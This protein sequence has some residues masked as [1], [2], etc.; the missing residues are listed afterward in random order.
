MLISLRKIFI[1]R[2]STNQ[3]GFTL[4]ETVVALAIAAMALPVLL[5][6]FSE[7]TKRH[8]M[9]EN[10]TTALYLLRLK[11]A[12]IEMEGYPE[13][14]SAEGEF[15]TDSRFTW[16]YE[17]METETEGLRAVTITIYWQERGQEKSVQLDTYMSDRTIEQQANQQQA[18][19][20]MR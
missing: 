11:A 4:I 14:G 7:G 3:R 19:V 8:S 16:A 18:N 9:I 13:V 12:E 10:K 1:R 20:G 5:R 6:A 15:G 17:V 2:T